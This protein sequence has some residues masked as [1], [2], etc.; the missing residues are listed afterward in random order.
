MENDELDG[1]VA[2]VT[3]E[4]EPGDIGDSSEKPGAAAP[5]IEIDAEKARIT[6]VAR[7]RKEAAWLKALEKAKR[8]REEE[9]QADA[10]R[11]AEEE[12][13]MIQT[14][15][16]NRDNLSRLQ[17][18]SE[19]NEID[20]EEKVAAVEGQ[21]EAKEEG[22]TKEKE[23]GNPKDLISK[24]GDDNDGTAKTVQD[25]YDDSFNDATKELHLLNLSPST[26]SQSESEKKKK[27]KKKKI[28]SKSPK[29]KEKKPSRKETKKGSPTE[30]DSDEK[31]SKNK[32]SRERSEEDDRDGE[33]KSD[34]PRLPQSPSTRKKMVGRI[35]ITGNLTK[36]RSTISNPANNVMD[37]SF[38]KMLMLDSD[39][40]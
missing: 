2:L 22:N 38:A 1:K 29:K 3:T 37:N 30:K 13:A 39:S 4:E 34:S 32:S 12:K 28:D 7:Q 6:E 35:S 9:A 40:D 16:A 10:E 20:G 8:Q 27:K 31:F 24:E 26:M 18:D 15:R 33:G 14:G 5:T 11:R 21:L 36:K 25:E 17:E 23:E 19:E